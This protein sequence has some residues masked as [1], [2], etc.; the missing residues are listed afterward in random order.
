MSL[1][2]SLF[3]IHCRRSLPLPASRG[4]KILCSCLPPRSWLTLPS[5]DAS[6]PEGRRELCLIGIPAATREGLEFRRME[7]EE[8]GCMLLFPLLPLRCT[9]RECCA[10]RL[11]YRTTA[12]EETFGGSRKKARRK[13]PKK[14]FSLLSPLWKMWKKGPRIS[15]IFSSFGVAAWLAKS[16]LIIQIPPPPYFTTRERT[17]GKKRDMKKRSTWIEDEI[18][19]CCKFDLLR[20]S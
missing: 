2:R 9:Q 18:E 4:L 6:T 1:D 3:Y 10:R 5:G 7:E 19:V 17:S 12:N 8:D 16:N 14:V 11:E 15:T 20:T 13:K